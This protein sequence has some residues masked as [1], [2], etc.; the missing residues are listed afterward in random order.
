M[1]KLM[2]QSEGPRRLSVLIIYNNKRRQRIRNCK[3]PENTH[4]NSGRPMTTITGEQNKH[5]LK[6]HARPE[7]RERFF[8]TSASAKFI[9][10]E[11]DSLNNCLGQLLWLSDAGLRS[12][13]SNLGHVIIVFKYV[14]DER[15][16][17]LNV[18]QKR[19]Q[20]DVRSV[21]AIR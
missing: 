16:A 3:S 5:P 4:L 11:A 17:S 13:K 2:E 1:R 8:G 18:P 14:A 12:D 6:F 10:A 20:Q 7:V 21:S 15:L 9:P 19:T